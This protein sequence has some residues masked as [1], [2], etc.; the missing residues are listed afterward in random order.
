MFIIAVLE[1]SESISTSSISCLLRIVFAA[2][3][4]PE[5]HRQRAATKID[6]VQLARVGQSAFRIHQF[7]NHR[8]RKI[9][10]SGLIPANIEWGDPTGC[11]WASLHFEAYPIA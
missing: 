8:V 4:P 7:H 3:E 6:D 2:A 11:S 10:L 9:Y 1:S 5:L